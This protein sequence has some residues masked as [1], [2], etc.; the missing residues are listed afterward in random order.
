RISPMLPPRLR[1]QQ[2]SLGHSHRPEPCTAPRS[3]LS[4]RCPSCR[5]QLRWSGGV[6][7]IQDLCWPTLS[8]HEAKAAKAGVPIPGDD[9]VVTDS[10]AEQLANLVNLLGHVDVGPGR[11]GVA[12]RMVV[13]EDAAGGLQFDGSS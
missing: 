4:C 11:G 7:G 5:L 6:W 1:T 2:A 10:D 13:D 3:W 9:D 12:G 8:S